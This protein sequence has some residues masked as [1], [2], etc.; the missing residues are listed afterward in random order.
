MAPSQRTKPLCEL[1][2]SFPV[3]KSEKQLQPSILYLHSADLLL[4][5]KLHLISETV[6][7]DCYFEKVYTVYYELILFLCYYYHTPSLEREMGA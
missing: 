3:D 1:L 4:L 5:S 7:K 6:L 2:A